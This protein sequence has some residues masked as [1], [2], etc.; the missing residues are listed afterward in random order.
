MLWWSD[1]LAERAAFFAE[2]VAYFTTLP[3]LSIKVNFPFQA[4]LH[5][6]PPKHLECMSSLI[7]QNSYNHAGSRVASRVTQQVATYP[8]LNRTYLQLSPTTSANAIYNNWP[9]RT[10]SGYKPPSVN[11][12][13]LSC[14]W[15]QE[16]YNFIASP[17]VWQLLSL[18]H[19]ELLVKG[20]DA[21]EATNMYVSCKNMGYQ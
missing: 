18:R 3:I 8:Y 2:R 20:Y 14:S 6:W 13:Y 1:N 21:Y 7:S 10:S 19:F 17:K 5:N 4:Q 11:P 16:P 12:L 15:K 9:H